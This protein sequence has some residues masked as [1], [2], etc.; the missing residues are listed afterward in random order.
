M[1][2]EQRNQRNLKISAA[3]F[4]VGVLIAMGRDQDVRQSIRR[5]E[6]NPFVTKHESLRGFVFVVATGKLN[7]VTLD[8]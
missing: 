6:A 5:I 7:E 1:K 4:G 8:S 2:P 3:A